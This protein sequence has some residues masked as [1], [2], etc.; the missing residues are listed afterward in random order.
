MVI[1]PE[2][3]IILGQEKFPNALSS[4]P[5]QATAVQNSKPKCG[6][7]SQPISASS[8]R[9]LDTIRAAIRCQC[10][11]CGTHKSRC[12]HIA[13]RRVSRTRHPVV[14]HRIGD[15]VL[16]HICLNRKLELECR[17]L[18]SPERTWLR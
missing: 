8:D 7:I 16:C 13:G 10:E 3:T 15:R 9:V 12:K 2:N 14:L 5:I 6:Q 17:R 18:Y 4:K 1:G 11:G